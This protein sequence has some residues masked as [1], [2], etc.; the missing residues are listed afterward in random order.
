LNSV[1]NNRRLRLAM[2]PLLPHFRAIWGVY[3]TGAG[4][5]RAQ[6]YEAAD[7]KSEIQ[8]ARP[9]AGAERVLPEV[10]FGPVACGEEVIADVEALARIER[11]CPKM[12]AVAMEGAGVAKAVLSTGT[13]PR[14]L[15]IRGVSDY[16][17]PEKN[18]GWHE[19]AANA[20]AAFTVG[21]LRS[22]PLAPGSPPQQ[23][24]SQ[25]NSA[26]TMVVIAQSFRG[27]SADEV[28]AVLDEDMKRGHLD[29]IHLDFTDLVRNRILTDPQVAADRVV[30]PQG[31]FLVKLAQRSEARLVFAGLAALP[32]VVLA[33]HVV[34]ARRHVRLFE[35]HE[36]DW[37]WPG[38]PAGFP[39]LVHSRL[40]R[41]PIKEPGEAVIRMAVSYPV[42]KADTD[43]VGLDPRL[44][45]DLSLAEPVRF[46]V[47]SEDQV[48][49]YG[50]MFRAT[51]DQ[52]RTVMP[53]CRRVH[54]FY[55]GPMALAFHLGQMISENIH[56][57]V[58]VWNYSRAYEWGIDLAAAVT[59]EPC[60]VGPPDAK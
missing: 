2:T 21:F 13:P 44:E 49:Q 6:H 48:R 36:H 31:A 54:I 18:D 8:V 14:Y 39:E 29:F 43:S 11:Q 47:K 56:P 12:V 5:G 7:W 30:A 17:G 41:R 4:L 20:A 22:R 37:A 24:A 60:V 26:P 51:L 52:L 25:E 35:F 16:A 1:V 50:R 15:E 10:K 3:Q 46:V 45:I 55:A 38:T 34:T 58:T 27:I 32:P 23:G 42:T 28:M 59:G 53:G 19:Y 9:D 40:P 33:G 57:P